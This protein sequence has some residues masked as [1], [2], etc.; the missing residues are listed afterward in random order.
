MKN[1]KRYMPWIL[2][3][4]AIMLLVIIQVCRRP[5]ARLATD[6]YYP[7]FTPVTAVENSSRKG[8]LLV[9]KKTALVSELLRLQQ[10]NEILNAELLQKREL[11]KQNDDLRQLLA[12]RK[13]H[14][15]HP[16]V[17]AELCGRDPANWDEEFRINKGGKHG[18]VVGSVVLCHIP[19]DQQAGSYFAV[20]GRITEVHD[21]T[22]TVTTILSRNCHLSVVMPQ[23]R[24]AGITAG[25]GKSGAKTRRRVIVNYLPRDMK[26]QNGEPVITSGLSKF[27]PSGLLLGHLGSGSGK[28]GVRDV[29]I[30]DRIYKEAVLTPAVDFDK[31]HY[32]IVMVQEK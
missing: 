27:T 30:K 25:N 17:F 18:L 5:L 9:K 1:I 29:K 24:S 16:L 26:Y 6:F 7:F 10:E 32:V 28:L 22:A 2:G 13:N 3:L 14:P 21:R 19:E 23:S 12:L 11:A 8:S 15:T 20:A 4:S 31:I